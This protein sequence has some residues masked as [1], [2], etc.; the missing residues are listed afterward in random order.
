VQLKKSGTQAPAKRVFSNAF[1]CLKIGFSVER[2]RGGGGKK[3]SMRSEL[4]L[5]AYT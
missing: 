3:A 2:E 1:G 4:R 5:L